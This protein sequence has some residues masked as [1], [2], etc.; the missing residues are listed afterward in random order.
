MKVRHIVVA[1]TVA[2]AGVLGTAGIATAQ[3]TT[4]QGSKR[5]AACAKATARIPQIQARITKVEARGALLATKLSTAQS[6]NQTERAKVLQERIDWN[7]TLHDHLTKTVD[8]I[9]THC[10][11]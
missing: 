2:L 8:E 4:S 6:K 11:A 3:T 10:P 5:A 9:N 7:N 1:S